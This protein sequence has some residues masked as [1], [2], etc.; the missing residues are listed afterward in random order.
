VVRLFYCSNS[1]RIESLASQNPINN[2]FDGVSFLPVWLLLQKGAD[3]YPA[4][5]GQGFDNGEN[6]GMTGRSETSYATLSSSAIIRRLIISAVLFNLLL[7]ALAAVTLYHHR[8][9]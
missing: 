5:G 8:S 3:A 2:S 9:Q 6:H 7:I 1:P 4:H